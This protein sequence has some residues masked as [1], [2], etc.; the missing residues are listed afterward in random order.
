[1]TFFSFFDQIP[2]LILRQGIIK[3]RSGEKMDLEHI[4]R[5][6]IHLANGRLSQPFEITQKRG[7]G[8]Q[9][10]DVV[11]EI[12]KAAQ[13][14]YIRM[15]FKYFPEFGVVAEEQELMV[16]CQMG[17]TDV[18][19]TVDPI[20]GTKALVRRQSHGIGTMIAL[21]HDGKIIAAYVGD[22]KTGEIY[23]YES[24]MNSDVVRIYSLTNR[25]ILSIDTLRP[26]SEQAVI[27]N[28][29]PRNYP[30]FVQAFAH[31]TDCGG[32][33]KKVR[34]TE[35]SLGIGIARL[36]KGE[37]GAAL[38]S[39]HPAPPWDITPVIGISQK[40]GFVFLRVNMET[41]QF[42]PYEPPISKKIE[43][44]PKY[45]LMIHQS[46]LPELRTWEARF[47]NSR[48]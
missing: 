25:E 23:G 13:E 34:T 47:H 11:T 20:D 35:G 37:I 14:T 36:W 33:F 45:V 39:I 44:G 18:Y 16:P 38:I 6:V 41:K 21:V 1:M 19:V 28:D 2:C 7:Y 8:G 43:W 29:D 9:M 42:E 26:L 22:V 27:L 5:D 40:M 46:R 30:P 24:A 32:L 4:V 12:D 17:G 15:L 31:K 3:P 48:L 10:D